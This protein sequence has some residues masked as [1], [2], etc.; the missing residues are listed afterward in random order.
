MAKRL[1]TIFSIL[2]LVAVVGFAGWWLTSADQ[3]P[4]LR[5]ETV[6]RGDVVKTVDAS[7]SA[8][9]GE[10]ISLAFASAGVVESVT[11][12]PGDRVE[13]GTTIAKLDDDTLEAI[14]AGS[15]A[16]V[17]QAQAN[18]RMVV[19]SGAGEN[20]RKIAAA[21]VNQARAAHE[22]AIIALRN[23]RLMMPV[24]GVITGVFVKAG[25]MVQ[26]IAVTFE[27]ESDFI[28]V[29]LF[30]PENDIARVAAGQDVV[31][32]VGALDQSFTT[33]LSLVYPA[34]TLI[35]G[36]PYFEAHAYLMFD[37]ADLDAADVRSGMTVDALIIVETQTSVL[38]VPQ[39]AIVMHDGKTFVRILDDASDVGYGEREVELGLRG[40]DGRV[41]VL[42]GLG[43]GDTVVTQVIED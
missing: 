23:A 25:E 39:R 35:E 10:S 1:L 8:Q 3:G 38:Y 20:S 42:S 2:A 37:D 40:D 5:T 41:V 26:G 43:E 28:D 18:E 15:A 29:T 24:D 13:A 12:M 31:V 11:V 30:V 6:K 17:A 32:E 16:S 27:T 36:V 14:V 4:E 21:S 33:T 34:A 19:A 22:Q 9:R 7:G